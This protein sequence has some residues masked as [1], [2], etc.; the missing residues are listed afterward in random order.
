MSTDAEKKHERSATTIPDDAAQPVEPW[1]DGY[2]TNGIEEAFSGG[3]LTRP[4]RMGRPSWS[5]TPPRP[6][7]RP[8]PTDAERHDHNPGRL[9][10]EAQR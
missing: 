6:R 5:A 3:T 9:G 2:R 8:S 1:E 7:S 4:S 10:R